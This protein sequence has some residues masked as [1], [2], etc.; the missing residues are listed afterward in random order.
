[1]PSGAFFGYEKA[2]KLIPANFEPPVSFE[3]NQ[4]Q[5]MKA[6]AFAPAPSARA[7]AKLL[8]LINP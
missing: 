5:T 4:T 3:A 8:L 2:S 6:G 7:L 1:M